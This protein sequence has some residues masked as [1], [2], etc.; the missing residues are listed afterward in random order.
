[1][2]VVAIVGPLAVALAALALILLDRRGRARP[3]LERRTFRTFAVVTDQGTIRGLLVGVYPDVLVLRSAV[4]LGDA[5]TPLEG[6]V[7]IPRPAVSWAQEIPPTLDMRD[8]A[9]TPRPS[10]REVGR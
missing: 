1:M 8:T 7:T 5:D 9:A 3:W 10:L 4:L 6:D 2:L